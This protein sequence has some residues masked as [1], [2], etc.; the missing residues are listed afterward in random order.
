MS[1][2]FS[3][4]E[5][6]RGERIMERISKFEKLE[7]LRYEYFGMAKQKKDKKKRLDIEISIK[8]D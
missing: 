8:S 6:E 7:K 3:E 2:N 4:N 5:N 1:D